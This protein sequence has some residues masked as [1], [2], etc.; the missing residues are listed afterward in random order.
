MGIRGN[1]GSKFPV[2]FFSSL[3]LSIFL[4]MNSNVLGK[5]CF[6]L[7]K[8]W[9]YF[10]RNLSWLISSITF[11]LFITFFADLR[12]I[13]L[14]S[15]NFVCL[16]SYYICLTVP[17]KRTFATNKAEKSH[18]FNHSSLVHTPSIFHA[19]YAS[20]LASYHMLLNYLFS[21]AGLA[22]FFGQ[23][24]AVYIAKKHL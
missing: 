17:Y 22:C 18:R 24:K 3:F 20:H 12:L 1:S 6:F 23:D 8:R 19:F 21:T 13:E 11:E 7:I 2:L 10:L 14:C 4:Q 16:T 15:S 5:N 9:E